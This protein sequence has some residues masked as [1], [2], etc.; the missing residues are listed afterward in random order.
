M[1]KEEYYTKI[2]YYIIVIHLSTRFIYIM[3]GINIVAAIIFPVSIGISNILSAC[4]AGA[5]LV[6]SY[7]VSILNKFDFDIEDAI[8][9][10]KGDDDGIDS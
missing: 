10:V 8:N 4:V 2:L 5:F 3:G 7:M 9:T 6:E 1:T